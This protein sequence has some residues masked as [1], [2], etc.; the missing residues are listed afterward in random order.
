MRLTQFRVK[1]YWSIHDSGEVGVE[2]SKTLLVGVNEAGK[3]ALLKALQQIKA[4]DD[5]EKFSAL[6]D[7][8]RSRYTEVQRG[9]KDAG[10][11][12][13]V[14]AKF[15]L[16]DVER[17]LV[18]DASPTSTDVTE[19]IIYRYLD[20]TLRWNFGS[21]KLHSQLS[22][23]ARDLARLRVYLAKQDGGGEVVAALDTLLAGRREHALVRGDFASKLLAWLET[24]FP[25]ID[26]TAERE[27]RRYDSLKNAVE[28][29]RRTTT[30]GTKMRERLPLFVYYSTYFTVRPR[31]NLASLAAREA[32]GDID[33][34]YDFGNLCLLRLLGL[35]AKELSE[36][37]AG[38]P[39][40][41]QYPY[42]GGVTG[43]AYL[44]AVR[45]H[46]LRLDDRHYRL[47][48]A[49]VDLTKSIREVWGDENVQLR[50]VPDGQYLKVVVVD[51]I[52]VEV[53][54]DQR[55][56]GFRWLVSFFV[57]FKA[58]AQGD[59]QNAILLL[60]EP[61]LSLHALKQQEFRKTVSRLAEDNQVIYTTHSPFLVGT[62]ELDLVRIVEMT[63][64]E[65]GTQVHT[66]L[67]VDDPR[68][69]YPLQIALG[70]ELAQSL[71][72]QSR[73]LVC[74]GLTD[75][76]YLEALNA[77][78][79]EVGK[80]LK[81]SIALVPASSASKVVYYATLLTSQRLKVAALLDSDQAG[82]NAAKQDE[83]VRL[84]SGKKLLRTKDYCDP[85]VPRAEIEDLLRATLVQV[86]KDALG[87]DITASAAAQPQRPVVDIFTKEIS[88]FS[89]YKLVRAFIGWLGS[90][91][92]DALTTAEQA[93]VTKLLADVNKAL[94]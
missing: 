68:S 53:E 40:P 15:S 28:L 31:I 80:G 1:D 30:A 50:L 67:V 48:A 85:V 12:L 91:G 2:P 42:N 5:A 76:M 63:S 78:A 83:L 92:F 65:A 52:G 23:I 56:E 20:N 81:T 62:D 49:S 29:D 13:V 41:N 88:G 60:D 43:E 84:L 64:R 55:S 8:P 89:K 82:D 36:L 19:L 21:A 66:R 58:Q 27:E 70:Y 86:A 59:L 11:V 25:L 32:A 14:E 6:R 46:Q 10:D 4:P 7:Y 26:E 71:F 74:E 90:R 22:D 37:A 77:A 17:Q 75:M 45:T 93:G 9:D 57:V 87:W 18:L 51:D 94:T 34:E 69:V 47:N 24:A 35:T 79:T 54:L 73:N 16:D 72:G 44:E 39:D 3:T 61:G 38:E 33:T